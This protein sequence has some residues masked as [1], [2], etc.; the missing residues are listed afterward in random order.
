[1]EGHEVYEGKMILTEFVRAFQKWGLEPGNPVPSFPHCFSGI[2]VRSEFIVSSC[3]GA[4]A[5]LLDSAIK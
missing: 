5:A 3:K 2:Q 1:M 4:K